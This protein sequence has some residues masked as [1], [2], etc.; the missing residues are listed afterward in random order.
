[1]VSEGIDIPHLRALI[2]LTT[3]TAPLTWTQILGR[4]LRKE[5]GVG[6][7][8]AHFYQYDDG[9]GY[10]KDDRGRML[11]GEA[12]CDINIRM[13]ALTIKE[14]REATIKQE[15]EGGTPWLCPVCRDEDSSFYTGKCPG[16]GVSPCPMRQAARVESLGAT[17]EAR[18]Q[19]YDGDEHDV[20]EL[21]KYEPI[22]V[23]W[24]W[25]LAKVKTHFDKLPPQILEELLWR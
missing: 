22:A 1:M 9:Y 21:G 11:L 14:E 6:E 25:P 19:F 8:C 23:R 12:P 2:Y 20:A 18:S 16:K 17:G 13:Y 5:A 10:P 4:I 3:T 7:Q 24:E 15:R